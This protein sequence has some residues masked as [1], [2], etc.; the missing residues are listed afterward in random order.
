MILHIACHRRKSITLTNE[1]VVSAALNSL[2]GVGAAIGLNIVN[3][4]YLG[5]CVMSPTTTNTDSRAH[6]ETFLRSLQPTLVVDQLLPDASPLSPPWIPNSE[7]STVIENAT[8]IQASQ[9]IPASRKS[10]LKVSALALLPHCN[11][12]RCCIEQTFHGKEKENTNR[13]PPGYP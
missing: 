3:Y 6:L 7:E 8:P 11:C 10:S 2:C 13:E 4:D 1:S 5:I 9:S 12:G